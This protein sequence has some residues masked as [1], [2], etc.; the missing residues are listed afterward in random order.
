MKLRRSGTAPQPAE[1]PRAVL[2]DRFIDSYV[3]WREAC[4][5]VRAA[6]ERWAGGESPRRDFAFERYRAAL[7]WEE[8]AAHIHAERTVLLA[9]PR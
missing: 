5:E 9:S 2:A 7:D 8:H 6:Y 3:S 1:A 4:E